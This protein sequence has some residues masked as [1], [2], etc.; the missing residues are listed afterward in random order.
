M[1]KH[2]AQPLTV[3][4]HK[5]SSVAALIAFVVA[6]VAMLLV[7]ANPSD[8]ARKPRL[9]AGTSTISLKLLDSTDGVAHWG[10][11]VT[12]DVFSTQTSQPWVNLVCSQNGQQVSEGWEGFFAGSL[13]G[14]FGLYSPMWTG[15]AAD[16]TA[17]LTDPSWTRL[18]S[19][20][21]HVYA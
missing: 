10:Q 8:A 1:S 9:P 7:T 11:R 21:F 13:E 17:W 6:S 20:S 14:I 16:C 12:F 19:V 2:T 3:A 15:G 18:T 4:S 5:V